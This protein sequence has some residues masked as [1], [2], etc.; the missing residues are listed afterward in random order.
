MLFGFACAADAAR[1]QS[2]MPA[3]RGLAR[4]NRLKLHLIKF[5]SRLD[6]EDIAP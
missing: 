5:I 2:M 4:A 1:L 3:A 6:I